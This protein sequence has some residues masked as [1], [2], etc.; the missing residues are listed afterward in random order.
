MVAG[1][2]PMRSIVHLAR[3]FALADRAGLLTD[4]ELASERMRLVLAV[5]GIE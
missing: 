2:E 3:L 5:A 1:Q 4:P